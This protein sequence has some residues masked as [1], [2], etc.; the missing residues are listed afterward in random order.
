MFR[1]CHSTHGFPGRLQWN[2]WQ[3]LIDFST[4]PS[5]VSKSRLRRH[6]KCGLRFG[7]PTTSWSSADTSLLDVWHQSLVCAKKSEGSKEIYIV[8]VAAMCSK[9]WFLWAKFGF[10]TACTARCWSHLSDL[11]LSSKLTRKERF[12]PCQPSPWTTSLHFFCQRSGARRASSKGSHRLKW[13]LKDPC[14][15]AAAQVAWCW[16]SGSG[17]SRHTKYW[18]MMIYRSLVGS[19]QFHCW[20]FL[21][22]AATNHRLW[23]LGLVFGDPAGF[24][25]QSVPPCQISRFLLEPSKWCWDRF[26]HVALVHELLHVRGTCSKIVVENCSRPGL[27]QRSCKAPA[28]HLGKCSKVVTLF[29]WIASFAGRLPSARVWPV[30]SDPTLEKDQQFALNSDWLAFFGSDLQ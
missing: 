1:L 8:P 26:E 20:F 4:V 12:Q 19:N 17:T 11:T 24:R 2:V 10:W 13:S 7:Q 16:E 21:E 18:P 3:N 23:A 6:C 27:D 9:A 28:A 5:L 30:N 29:E 14:A 22:G 25:K 15:G